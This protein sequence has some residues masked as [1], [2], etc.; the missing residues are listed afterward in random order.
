MVK[1]PGPG[2]YETTTMFN[3]TGLHYSSKFHSMM[4]KTMSDRPKDFYAPYKASTTPGPGSYDVFSDFNGYTDIHK[5]CKCGR[6]LGHPPIT[7]GSTVCTRD[8]KSMTLSNDRKHK[9]SK[10]LNIND[11]DNNSTYGSKKKDKRYETII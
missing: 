5:K 8:G 2:R 6:R 7:E 10:N 4:A 9:K 3:R 11:N 1:T